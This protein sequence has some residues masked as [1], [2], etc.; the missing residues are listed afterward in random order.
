MRILAIDVGTGTQDILL[1]D[2]QRGMENCFKMVMPAPTVLLAGAIRTA[3]HGAEDVLLTGVT[4]GGGPCAWAVSDHLQAGFR[5]YATE[6][7]ACT[8][9]DDLDAVA[10]MGVTL[11]SD[12][13]A[14]SLDS[15]VRRLH[16]AD[17]DYGAVAEAFRHFGVDLDVDLDGI[18]VAVFDH[19][20]APPGVSDRV[21]RFQYLE[22]R[23]RLDGRLSTFAFL[24][25]DVPPVMT[26][27]LAVAESSPRDDIPLLLMDTA[28][29]AGLG[30]LEDG[31]V[32]GWRPV[33]VVNVGNFHCLAFRLGEEGVEGLFEHHTGKL[34][35]GQLD[36]LLEELADGRLTHAQVFGS[37]GHGAVL[38]RRDPIALNERRV[39]VTGPRRGLLRHSR[40]RPHFAAPFGDM[41][42]TGCFGL[43]RAYGEVVPGVG[44]VIDRALAGDGSGETE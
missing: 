31:T 20:H 12:D 15:G 4:M 25:A 7:A 42:I 37:H 17:F 14:R 39:V 32:A 44:E 19:G 22:E 13:E 24:A 28:P 35:A 43:I 16:T 2:S 3:T 34:S 6:A 10:E 1:F 26:R 36:A 21:F 40:M 38:F 41:M 5:V 29:A 18:A 23:L 11:V 8:F 30:A 33:I 9:N 27:M